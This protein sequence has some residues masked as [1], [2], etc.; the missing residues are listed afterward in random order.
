MTA[1][2][3][4]AGELPD[5]ADPAVT[6]VSVEK[7]DVANL[8]EQPSVADAVVAGWTQ[9]SWPEHLRTV[10]CF[11]SIDPVAAVGILRGTEP[12]EGTHLE[13]LTYAQWT[14]TPTAPALRTFERYRSYQ[15]ATPAP[16]P[17]CLVFVT[18]DFD[19]PDHDRQR[20]WIDGVVAALAAEPEPAPGLI[21]AHFHASTDGTQV[22]NYAEWTSAQAHRDALESGPNGIGQAE[23]AE[24]RHVHEFPGVT[25]NT[26]GRYALHR[27]LTPDARPT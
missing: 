14:S 13:V 23:L 19:G 2:G 11:V 10:S 20:Q 5:V 6:V 24:W 16:R 4:S 9:Q 17:G 3:A 21:A 26:V 22:L 1:P 27:C 18:I 25:G 15:P 8:I 12:G 7:R